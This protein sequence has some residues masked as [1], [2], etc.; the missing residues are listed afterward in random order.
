[1][2][3]IIRKN[4]PREDLSADKHSFTNPTK[5]NFTT[6]SKGTNKPSKGTNPNK[7]VIT[8]KKGGMPSI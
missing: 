6:P 4:P 3:K 5:G 2:S 8:P 1:M 7:G